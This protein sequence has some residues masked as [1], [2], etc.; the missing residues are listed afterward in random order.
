VAQK[1]DKAADFV[2]VQ[3]IEQEPGIYDRCHPDYS[4]QQEVDSSWVRILHGMKESDVCV[5]VCVCMCAVHY[6]LHLKMMV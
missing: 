1:I 5:C 4:R 2:F 3:L 6:H